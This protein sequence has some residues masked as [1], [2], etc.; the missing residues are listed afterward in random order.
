MTSPTTPEPARSRAPV[1]S[2]TRF[3]LLSGLGIALA[4]A[5][6][7]VAMAA[8]EDAPG[9]AV[10]LPTSEASPTRIP[11]PRAPAPAPAPGARASGSALDVGNGVAVT[12][13]SAQWWIVRE[14]TDEVTVSHPSGVTVTMA[15]RAGDPATARGACDELAAGIAGEL[16]DARITACRDRDPQGRV[17]VAAGTVTGTL[18]MQQGSAVLTDLVGTGVRDDRLVT[19]FQA[20]YPGTGPPN[21]SVHGEIGLLF[22]GFLAAQDDAP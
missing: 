20:A 2:R 3:L 14:G 19:F 6:G 15:T 4:T 18:A 16:G 22:T 9:T 11:G 13:P 12:L 5:A 8:G 7:L 17:D 10:A 1:T 21:E